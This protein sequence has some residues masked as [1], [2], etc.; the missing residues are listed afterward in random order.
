[1]AVT[2]WK[3]RGEQLEDEIQ[4]HIEFETQKNIQSGMSPADAH[5]G[6]SFSPRTAGA[7]ISS[8]FA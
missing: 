8:G 2:W 3:R 5:Y 4:N 1:V 7:Q 6:L